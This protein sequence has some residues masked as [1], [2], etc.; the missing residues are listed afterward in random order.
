M[1]LSGSKAMQ[2]HY[3]FYRWFF[4]LERHESGDSTYAYMIPSTGTGG[5]KVGGG[6]SD[7][8]LILISA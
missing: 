6:A 1:K 3:K 4:E 5:H 7:P 8:V 2:G